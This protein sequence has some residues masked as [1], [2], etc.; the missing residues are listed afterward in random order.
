[1]PAK[2][3]GISMNKGYEGTVARSADS[4]IV[5]RAAAEDILFG[6]A[7]IL[8]TNG[9]YALPTASTTE[10]SV[11][12]V[13]VREVVQTNTYFPQTNTGYLAK[14]PMDVLTR[15]IVTVKCGKGT[16][17]PGTSVFVCITADTTDKLVPG[18]F[19]AE[20]ATTAKNTVT[21]SNMKWHSTAD[22]NGIA[23]LLIATRR[24]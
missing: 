9:N 8:D 6:K 21:V 13:S 15:G 11:V 17:K 3:I 19:A 1:M 24:D 16:P 12:G 2:V 20:A 22:A 10:D 14:T 4:I 23:E 5:N 7:V 18:D